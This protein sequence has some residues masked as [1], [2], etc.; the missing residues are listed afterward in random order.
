MRFDVLLL[1][2]MTFLDAMLSVMLLL[3]PRGEHWRLAAANEAAIFSRA[4]LFQ[5]DDDRTDTAAFVLAIQDRESGLHADAAG[6]CPGMKPGDPECDVE[7]ATSFGAMQLHIARARHMGTREQVETGMELVRASFHECRALPANERLAYYARGS[8]ASEEG[9][10]ISRD[11]FRHF[12][13]IRQL[14]KQRR[15][16]EKRT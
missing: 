11:R 3:A 12:E 9:R 6:D 4:P 5:H 1:P 7:Y 14:F 13:K 10:R 16:D 8:C 2:T 15:Q